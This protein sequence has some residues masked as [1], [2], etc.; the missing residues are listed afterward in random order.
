MLHK[1]LDCRSLLGLVDEKP[2]WRLSDGFLWFASCKPNSELVVNNHT[3][4]HLTF[5]VPSV[6]VAD[7]C[8]HPV[9]S[10]SDGRE[11]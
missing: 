4:V 9:S 10:E 3:L 11:G 6:Y 2:A 8:T 5:N 1:L 7:Y